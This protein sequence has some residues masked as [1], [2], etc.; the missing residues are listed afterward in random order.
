[1]LS[2]FT[3]IWGWITWAVQALLP[4]K[5]NRP[6]GPLVRWIVWIV[7]D[8]AL[9]AVLYLI[10]DRFDFTGAVRLPRFL[11]D[12][13][14]LRHWYLPILGQLLVL[15]A[16][17]LYWF[18][19]LWFSPVEASPF[20]DIDDAWNEA[21]RALGQAGIQLPNLPLFLILGR[22][23]AEEENLFEASGLK[24]V[25]KLT[26]G[27]PH[28]PVHVCADREGVYV[29]CRGAS[30]LGKLAS[31]LALED[32]PQGATAETAEAAENLERT[33][34]AGRKE[35]GLIDL[36]RA[37]MGQSAT[38]AHKRALRRAA[39][40]RPLGNDLL[41]EAGE[42]ARYKARLAHL[43]RLILRDRQP[44]C[45]ANGILVLVP[46]GGTDT[47]AEA[48]LTAQAVQDDLAVARQESKL[49][50]PLVA[51]LADMEEITG[52]T[53]FIQRQPP[54]EIGN[55]R[56]SGFPMLTRLK[57]EE[58]LDQVRASVSW[59]CTTYMQDNV[60]RVL[61]SES[62][63]K[64]DVKPLL[65]ANGRLALLLDEM[66][67]RSE[68]LIAIVQQAIAP[69][70]DSMFRYSGCYLAAT[71]PRGSQAFVA[72][73]FQKLLKE[74]NSV[75]WTPRA[76]TEDTENA[77]RALYAFAATCVLT[78]LWLLLLVWLIMR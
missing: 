26:P 7:L 28:A 75:T 67:M 55:R 34:M 25:V 73:V 30:V 13:G 44:F 22:P 74:Q 63:A 16:V 71:G 64:P 18:Y 11:A 20:P 78:V 3:A 50:C 53:D 77:G 23:A 1:M 48:Q 59:I 37:S 4:F 41:S 19:L 12:A 62:A 32:V 72:G 46:A 24:L 2:I 27:N 17:V 51:V 68:P 65:P 54:G 5:P 42:V 69:P 21:M 29:T 66:H 60:Y 43:C 35:Q 8:L 40:G 56:G 49:D 76:V 61:A 36:L 70:Q 58:L 14:W 10:N 31:I 57:P 39:L 6:I 9:L 52:F 47:A 15:T 45:A 33:H 38:P